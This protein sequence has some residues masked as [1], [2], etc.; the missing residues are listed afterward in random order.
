MIR[1]LLLSLC[2]IAAP[3]AQAGSLPLDSRQLA[4]L[5]PLEATLAARY[6]FSADDIHQLFAQIRYDPSVMASMNAPAENLPWWRY[7]AIFITPKRI[8]AGAAFLAAHQA[9]LQ[10]AAQQYGVA[11]A[12]IVAILGVETYYGKNMGDTPVLDANATLYLTHPRRYA[13]FGHQ[14]IDF[15]RLCRENHLDPLGIK[16]SYAGAMGMPQFIASSYLRYAVDADGHGADLWTSMP[17]ITASVAHYF[18]ASGWHPGQPV[19]MPAKLTDDAHPDAF[20]SANGTG[21]FT[22]SQLAAAGIRP[23]GNAQD[24]DPDLPVGLLRLVGKNGPDYFICW[25]NFAVIQRYNSSPLYAMAVALLM[26]DIRNKRSG[27]E[28]TTPLTVTTS[29]PFDQ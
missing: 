19:A 26:Q 15:L 8:D 21:H 12:L 29:T 5:E 14:L 20:V 3:L 22:L 2:L 9:S 13:F 1:R 16:G 28:P 25:N 23:R 10:A 6:G 18:A 11:R 7:R 4:R 24:I 17:D 27:G